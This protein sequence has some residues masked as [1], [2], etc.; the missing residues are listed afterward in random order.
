LFM[1]LSAAVI[2]DP[3]FNTTPDIFV[4]AAFCAD[5]RPIA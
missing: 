1:L 3:S 4:P 2:G 5:G